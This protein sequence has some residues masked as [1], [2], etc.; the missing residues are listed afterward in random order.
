MEAAALEPGRKMWSFQ[1]DI[2]P[3]SA[4]A[5]GTVANVTPQGVA[6]GTSPF[7]LLP[8]FRSQGELFPETAPCGQPC[9]QPMPLLDG[10]DGPIWGSPRTL[11]PAPL[12]P[13]V[14]SWTSAPEQ[15]DSW[16]WEAW[17]TAVGWR[18]PPW[19]H[20]TGSGLV[21]SAC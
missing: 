16:N 10:L 9:P 7:C 17:Q 4:H 6:L 19:G 20:V 14:R 15:S 1:K 21:V 8:W 12:Q 18:P 5:L 13:P 11:L 3:P 2:L